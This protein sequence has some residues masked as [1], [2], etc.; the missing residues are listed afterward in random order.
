MIREGSRRI[1]NRFIIFDDNWS[2]NLTSTPL[3]NKSFIN[4]NNTCFKRTF[5]SSSSKNFNDN[6][7]NEINTDNLK[8][9][10]YNT[11]TND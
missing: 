3:N 2:N 11:N 7:N 4:N 5:I 1:I 6:I 9:K 10:N 8:I